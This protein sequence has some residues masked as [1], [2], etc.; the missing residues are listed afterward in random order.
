MKV[1]K[2]KIVLCSKIFKLLIILGPAPLIQEINDVSEKLPTIN[3]SLLQASE[4]TQNLSKY[5]YVLIALAILVSVAMIAVAALT[6]RKW[7]RD[8]AQDE[9]FADKHE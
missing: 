7:N 9:E 4:T 8:K 2:L 3:N 6:H 1:S 5:Y